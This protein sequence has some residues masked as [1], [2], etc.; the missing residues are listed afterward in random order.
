M[1]E[2]LI[3]YRIEHNLTQ[4]QVAD[5][6]G[7]ARSYYNMIERDK[8]TPSVAVA[9]KIAV[10]LNFDWTFFFKVKGNETTQKSFVN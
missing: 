1:R 9:Q 2:W 3:K 6:V 5:S 7:V 10:T 8:R 4:E